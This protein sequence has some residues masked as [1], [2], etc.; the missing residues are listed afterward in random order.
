[1][2]KKKCTKSKSVG[3]SIPM[4]AI[5]DFIIPGP[6]IH[7]IK[8]E[9]LLRARTDTEGPEFCAWLLLLEVYW[10]KSA[11]KDFSREL[12]KKIAGRLHTSLWFAQAG[13]VI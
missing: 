12:R 8:G 13:L 1:M 10:V 2:L 9:A 4:Q 6:D 5:S 7:G 3:P 11:V